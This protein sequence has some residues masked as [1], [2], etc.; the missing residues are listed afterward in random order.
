MKEECNGGFFLPV[1]KRGVGS[2]WEGDVGMGER[3]WGWS[4]GVL[5]EWLK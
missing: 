1:G 4:E 2:K 5:G 3:L